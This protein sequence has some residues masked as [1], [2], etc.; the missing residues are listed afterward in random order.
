[1]IHGDLLGERSAL[2]PD[3]TA[4]VELA[5]GRRFS[6]R[7]LDRRAI[8]C[9]RMWLYGLGVRPGDRVGVLAD[10]RVEFHGNP[11]IVTEQGV[12]TARS[13]IHYVAEDRTV[14]RNP[15]GVF[16]IPEQEDKKEE[17]DANSAEEG[18]RP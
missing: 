7:E 4:L 15:R 5:S 12:L 18:T 6:Y 9:A 8:G 17:D 11:K 1:M 14:V 13:F 2:S 16:V 3:R 10:N